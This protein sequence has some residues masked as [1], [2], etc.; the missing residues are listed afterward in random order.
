LPADTGYA[1]IV[2]LRDSDDAV[3]L[4]RLLEDVRLP[5]AAV[6][7]TFVCPP[8]GGKSF[9]AD[10][11]RQAELDE[12]WAQAVPRN[13]MPVFLLMHEEGLAEWLEGID[14]LLYI[15]VPD[16]SQA[17]RY[18]E[19]DQVRAFVATGPLDFATVIMRDFST[20]GGDAAVIFDEGEALRMAAL[21]ADFPLNFDDEFEFDSSA[22]GGPASTVP[23]PPA[24]GAGD[25][26]DLIPDFSTMF[27][28][29][30]GNPPGPPPAFGGPPGYGAPPPYPPGGGGG[31][32]GGGQGGGFAP[33]RPAPAAPPAGPHP[34]DLLSGE[35]AQQRP[36]GNPGGG[37]SRASAAEPF[38]APPAS[39]TPAAPPRQA[40]PF[41]SPDPFGA[42]PARPAAG[43]PA[44][45]TGV[46]PVT[47]PFAASPAQ[48]PA[49]D[50]F[51]GDDEPF[52][53]ATY[54]APPEPYPGRGVRSG[55]LPPSPANGA[56]GGG[57]A[58]EA[59]GDAV[60]SLRERLRSVRSALPMPAALSRKRG[61]FEETPPRELARLMMERGPTI[62]VMGSRKGGVGKTS[63]AAGVA[64]VGGTILDG[65]GH[66]A[67]IVD[68][69]IANPDAW[70]QM[71]LREGAATVREV[72]AALTVNRDPPPPVHAT[73]P[74][75]AC[76]PESRETSEYSKTDIKRFADYLRRRYTFIV[77]DMSNRLPDPM[78][79]PEAAVA[80]YWL[81][82]AD[83]L[84][85]PTTSSKQDFNGVLDYL[86]V[87]GL[88]PTVVP[89][90][91]PGVKRNRDHPV[92]QQYLGV[93]RDRVHRIVEIPDEADKVRLAGMEGVP[94][95]QLSPA[96]RSA[97]RE[98]TEVVVRV[99]P[100]S[101]V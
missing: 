5:D 52:G 16:A 83:V 47:D 35:E 72:V 56:G 37:S 42:D 2:L 15:G 24:F 81:E 82:H 57:G 53:A 97:Y 78:A 74:A 6:R 89:Y 13:D 41:A 28:D 62:V 39:P 43:Q 63:Y 60:Q 88:P 92:T 61:S 64:I 91:V 18:P 85:L 94:V 9:F 31:G 75:L 4:A 10:D 55:Q 49:V 44:G 25:P 23:P 54:S 76:Y 38:G 17:A 3:G 87:R 22:D 33:P 79:G 68:A 46:L 50:P 71:N 27:P 34:F 70:G 40:E 12:W 73:T 77:V 21:S 100:R 48:A 26:G 86:D 36:P 90:I 96:L 58:G 84:V 59:M 1:F 67:A 95:E 8:V 14:G 99:P 66:K 80:A 101:P 30:A 7:S 32:G 65:V 20:A 29:V 45:R 69:N 98:L 19:T 93:I 11:Q 51:G